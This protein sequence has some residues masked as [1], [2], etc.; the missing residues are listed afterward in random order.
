MT[1]GQIVGKMNT[2]KLLNVPLYLGVP[3]AAPHRER[4]LVLG[5]HA[6]VAPG[7][8]NNQH[9]AVRHPARA[10]VLWKLVC[11]HFSLHP[12]VA[13]AAEAGGELTFDWW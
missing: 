5:H 12:D 2:E 7:A 6:A 13:V 3:L 10:W 4:V 11:G 9:P 8:A 1:H